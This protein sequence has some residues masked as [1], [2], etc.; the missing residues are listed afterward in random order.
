MEFVSFS[1]LAGST[2]CRSAIWA[3]EIR[4]QAKPKNDQTDLEGDEK[5]LFTP[6][7]L[8]DVFDDTASIADLLECR[9]AALC[10][11]YN[12]PPNKKKD[13]EFAQAF[14]EDM[15]SSVEILDSVAVLVL[16]GCSFALRSFRS[17]G[18][19]TLRDY[20]AA[21]SNGLNDDLCDALLKPLKG[22]HEGLTSK[23]TNELRDI[24]IENVQA[25]VWL[26]NVPTFVA[27]VGELLVLRIKNNLPF[28][29]ESFVGLR[30]S[31]NKRFTSFRIAENYTRSEAL[32]VRSE[33]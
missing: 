33:T 31:G 17:T 25:V 11:Q 9:C 30:R 26:V 1:K 24:F 18:L 29:D 15:K 4:A 5:L 14:A 19:K 16:S 3:K 20:I 2:G 23:T 6:E 32:K 13:I 7:I 21:L 8:R 27:G 22:S 28:L 10:R 12:Q